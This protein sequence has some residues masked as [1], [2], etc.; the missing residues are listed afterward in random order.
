MYFFIART[1]EG[2]LSEASR[3][4]PALR[5]VCGRLLPPTTSSYKQ[6]TYEGKNESRAYSSKRDHTTSTLRFV[7]PDTPIYTHAFGDVEVSDIAM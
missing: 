1:W 2:D 6:Y 4:I 3:T 5:S 7:P